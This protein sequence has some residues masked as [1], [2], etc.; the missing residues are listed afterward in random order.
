MSELTFE[1]LPK[2]VGDI[3]AKMDT[4]EQLLLQILGKGGATVNPNEYV[5]IDEAAKI[6]SLSKQTIYGLTHRM[7]IPHCKRGKRLYFS[8]VELN[9]WIATTRRKTVGE[10][11]Q[12][13]INYMSNRKRR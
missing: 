13:A 12:E 7:E 2:A 3:R 1:Q 6:L 8:R 11:E 4:I 9:A 5:N 10:I